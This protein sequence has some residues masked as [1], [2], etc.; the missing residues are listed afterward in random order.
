MGH[1]QGEP[2]SVAPAERA[3]VAVQEWPLVSGLH[4]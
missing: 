4:N 3:Q 2:R 1:S